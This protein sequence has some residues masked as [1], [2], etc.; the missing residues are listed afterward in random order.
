MEGVSGKIGAENGTGS[1]WPVNPAELIQIE[2][3][4]VRLASGSYAILVFFFCSRSHVLCRPHV[5]IPTGKGVV[6]LSVLG[7]TLGS[8]WEW[9]INPRFSRRRWCTRMQGNVGLW[10]SWFTFLTKC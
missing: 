5:G 3:T 8:C 7:W 10:V 6:S 4:C 9:H 1:I 2:A